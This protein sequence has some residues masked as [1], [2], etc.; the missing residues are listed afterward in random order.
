MTT[1][2][3]GTTVGRQSSVSVAVRR[4]LGRSGVPLMTLVAALATGTAVAQEEQKSA[5]PEVLQEVT[6]SGTRIVRT[7]GYQAPTPVSVLG[8]DDLNKSPMR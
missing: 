2:C 7:D 3:R 6:V 5:P 4:A 8:A 1:N